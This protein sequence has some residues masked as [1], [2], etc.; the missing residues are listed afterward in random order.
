MDASR[1]RRHDAARGRPAFPRGPSSPSS[2]P[3][4]PLSPSCFSRMRLRITPPP[5][6]RGNVLHRNDGA[7]VG[8]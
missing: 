8:R 5:R 3:P 2:P 4:S 1:V 6:G 7:P